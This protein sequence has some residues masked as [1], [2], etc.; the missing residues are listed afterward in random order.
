VLAQASYELDF[1]GKNRNAA[2][3]AQALVAASG[4]DADT[5]AMTLSASVANGYFTLLSL[6]ER[7]A[8]AR[9]AAQAARRQLDLIE[10]QRRLGT[11]SDLQ[12]HQQETALST[13]LAA[14]PALMQQRAAARHALAVLCGQAPE[15]FTLGNTETL[16]AITQPAI[17]PAMPA[18]LLAL[19]PDIQAAEARLRSANFD[20]GMA[21]AAFFPACRFRLR[22]GSMR[23]APPSCFRLQ[24][25]AIWGAVCWRRCFRVGPC[26]A[27]SRWIARAS[28]NWSPP[29]ARRC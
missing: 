4:F 29:I 16:A 20:I 5:V 17:R 28:S 8:L 10:T 23:P 14:V 19:R 6:D 3:S 12:A 21:R 2:A 26:L 25:W 13:Y 27:G 7:I 1:W 18:E 11:A 15:E 24:R 22:A 9:E